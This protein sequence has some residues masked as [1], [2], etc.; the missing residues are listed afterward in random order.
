MQLQVQLQDK[1]E[2]LLHILM[3]QMM[4]ELTFNHFYKQLIHQH[5]QLKVILE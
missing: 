4:M 1:K 3:Q 2:Q 5:Q